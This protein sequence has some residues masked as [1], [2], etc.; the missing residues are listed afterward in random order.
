MSAPAPRSSMDRLDF[1]SSI[2][3]TAFGVAVLV[4]SL[5]LPRLENLKVNPY[6]VP[7]LVP[8]LL[9]V[10]IAAC[11]LVILLRSILR[12]G[13]RAG[14]DAMDWRRSAAVRRTLVT[15]ALTLVYALVLFPLVPFRIATPLFVFVF[16]V[17]TE[18]MMEGRRPGLRAM[19]TA[20][21]VALAT[22]L[23]VGYVFQ[24]LFFVRLP[25]G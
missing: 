24:H 10:A 12:G 8:G 3:L 16:I 18:A 1:F 11:G 17:S 21:L 13:W 22:G 5:R 23:V 7:G 2:L 14:G 9:G 25:G 4:E 6:T 19:V 15:L 20:A